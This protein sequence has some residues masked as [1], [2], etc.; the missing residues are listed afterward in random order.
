[1]KIAF[2]CT[3]CH[4]KMF[5]RNKNELF[6]LWLFPLMLFLLFSSLWGY[7][8]GYVRFLL[9]GIVGMSVMNNGLVSTGPFLNEQYKSG[10]LKLLNKQDFKIIYYFIGYILSKAIIIILISSSLAIIGNVVYNC[11][12]DIKSTGNC[13][14]GII[15]GMLIFSFISL[16]ITLICIKTNTFSTIINL[17]NYIILFSSDVF[18]PAS[19]TNSTIAIIATC[20]PMNAI[21]NIIRNGDYNQWLLL[22]VSV[23]VLLFVKLIKVIDFS[24]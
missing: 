15:A 16:D 2:F 6:Y 19:Q 5:L 18:Y 12:I 22:W 7:N 1:M 17:I 11:Q 13:L 8:G 9:F 20:F 4:F 10:M 24:R 14:M 23:P 21:L 3:Y